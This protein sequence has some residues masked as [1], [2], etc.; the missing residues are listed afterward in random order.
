M[1]VLLVLM[2]L[3]NH[4]LLPR[5]CNYAQSLWVC[6]ICAGAPRSPPRAT[7]RR[8]TDTKDRQKEPELSPRCQ[9]A[10]L[11]QR[12]H[13][14]LLQ[15]HRRASSP[16]A[17]WTGSKVLGAK[18]WREG[19]LLLRLGVW[20]F[21]L[22]FGCLWWRWLKDGFRMSEFVQWKFLVLMLLL[23]ANVLHAMENELCQLLAI[24]N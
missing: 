23:L 17:T 21:V 4:S 3:P 13:R 22:L 5:R 15:R 18:D 24:E 14:L 10:E 7:A 8:L 2:Y 20:L 19:L 12:P 9:W 1:P 6:S 11:C 16:L